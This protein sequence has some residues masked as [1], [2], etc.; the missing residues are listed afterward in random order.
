M[1]R[2]EKVSMMLSAGRCLVEGSDCVD[3]SVLYGQCSGGTCACGGLNQPCCPDSSGE[4]DVAGHCSTRALGC[5]SSN[6]MVQGTCLTCGKLAG[7]CCDYE[8]C[9]GNGLQ[10][11]Y[12]DSN[13]PFGNHSCQKCGGVGEACCESDYGAQ[14]CNDPGTLCDDSTSPSTCAVCGVEGGPCCSGDVCPDSS[15]TCLFRRCLKCGG[16]GQPCCAGGAC[17]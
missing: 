17:S 2:A 10:C 15:M 7:P 16:A 8:K 3:G 11:T 4:P 13:Y 9:E 1:V 5:S 12:D 6:G 14:T